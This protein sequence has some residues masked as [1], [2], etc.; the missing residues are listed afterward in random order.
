[1][2]KTIRNLAKNQT[3]KGFVLGLVA[4]LGLAMTVEAPPP[5]FIPTQSLATIVF[6]PPQTVVNYCSQFHKNIRAIACANQRGPNRGAIMMPHACDPSF[7]NDDYALL[8]CHEL[9]HLNGWKHK[10]PSD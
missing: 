5:Q 2:L 10:N 3:S 9:S 6:A 1:M 7:K 4:A 8:L